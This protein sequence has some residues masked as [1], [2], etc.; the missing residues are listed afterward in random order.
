MQ[1][2]FVYTRGAAERGGLAID[3]FTV[4]QAGDRV[5]PAALSRWMPGG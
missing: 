1:F 5:R 3:N 4:L 2:E